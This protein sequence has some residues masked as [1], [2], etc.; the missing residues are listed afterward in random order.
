MR[1]HDA[2]AHTFEPPAWLISGGTVAFRLTSAVVIVDAFAGRGIDQMQAA[3]RGTS[4]GFIA[5]LLGLVRS[6]A[7][8]PCTRRP[9]LLQRKRNVAMTS[10]WKSSRDRNR[11]GA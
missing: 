10:S 6:S 8:Q 2:R 5:L 3:A 7:T 1:R 11:A 4:H 9:L